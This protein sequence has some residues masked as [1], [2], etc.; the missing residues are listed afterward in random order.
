MVNEN[1]LTQKED[2]V[3]SEEACAR[4]LRAEQFRARFRVEEQSGEASLQALLELRL[5]RIV[6]TWPAEEDLRV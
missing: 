5:Q 3:R 1:R 2:E 6:E 4:F